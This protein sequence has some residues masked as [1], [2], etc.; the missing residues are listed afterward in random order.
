[1][2]RIG[3]LV[4]PP[5][6]YCLLCYMRHCYVMRQ[7]HMPFPD[8]SLR[9]F[10]YPSAS[11]QRQFYPFSSAISQCHF[12]AHPTPFL[13]PLSDTIVAP[14]SSITSQRHFP[15]PFPATFYTIFQRNVQARFR[16]F[17]RPSSGL[18]CSPI[19]QLHSPAPF[20]S[21]ISQR[22]FQPHSTLLS[23][24]FPGVIWMHHF[25]LQANASSCYPTYSNKVTFNYT[26]GELNEQVLL[27]SPCGLEYWFISS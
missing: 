3:S 11:F 23:A 25:Q 16:S 1:M 18:V 10:P 22:H 24:P 6:P 12:Q 13:A 19:F 17:S 20:L 21:A 15:A 2:R 5:Q 14:F 4:T 27:A 8:A 7:F 26:F 9:R